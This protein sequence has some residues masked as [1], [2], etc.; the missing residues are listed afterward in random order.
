MTGQD[1]A[2]AVQYKLPVIVLVADNGI[3]GTIRMHQER[4]YPGRV[5]ATDLRNPDFAGYALAFG[6]YGA[7]VEKSADF[8]AA[9]AGARASGKPS[10]IHLKIDPEAI[11]PTRE[12][13]RDTGE[14]AR[15][16]RE[17]LRPRSGRRL[18]KRRESAFSLACLIA[19]PRMWSAGSQ[20]ASRRSS[21]PRTRSSGK[22]AWARCKSPPWR[23]APISPPARS[24]A[25]SRRRT[26]LVAEVIAAAAC[27]E[28]VAMHAAG[29]AAPGPLSAV[30]ACV[31]TFAAR[32]LHDRR[33]AWAMMAEPIDPDIDALRLNFRRA[34]A[35]ELEMRISTAIADG[36]LPEQDVRVAAPGGDRR[37]ARG[38]ARAA[39]AAS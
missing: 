1:F 6:G 9:F 26:H 29:D 14:V 16:R 12:P 24:T 4:E 7:V 2:T 23:S 36:H 27:R 21:V 31:A 3:Y 19:A 34:I 39:G 22:R 20:S 10:I 5:I 11:T 18:P 25:I 13:D 30:A 35:A 33:L 38:S 28:L 17:K 8:P 37:L 32:A 15:R